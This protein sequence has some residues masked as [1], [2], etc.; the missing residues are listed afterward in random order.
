MKGSIAQN[1]M[2]AADF[3]A[4]FDPSRHKLK[5]AGLIIRKTMELR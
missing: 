5:N 1:P 2:A 3:V 4:M